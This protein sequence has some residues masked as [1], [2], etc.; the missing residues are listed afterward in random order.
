MKF[1]IKP[2]KNN[3]KCTKL[4]KASKCTDFTTVF[5]CESFNKVLFVKVPEHI[6]PLTTGDL[7]RQLSTVLVP[8]HCDTVI[9]VSGELEFGML[10]V[11][12]D[13]E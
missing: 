5:T 13:E 10:E 8:K 6:D 1:T 2:L 12:A 3:S 4:I 7:Y 9:L 11:V